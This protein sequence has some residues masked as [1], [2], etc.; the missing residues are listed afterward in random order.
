MQQQQ[1]IAPV[2]QQPP[3]QPTYIFLVSKEGK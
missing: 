3:P 1:P 2:I